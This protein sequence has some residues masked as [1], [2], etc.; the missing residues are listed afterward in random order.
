M[1]KKFLI[2]PLLCVAFCFS[3]MPSYSENL[4][5]NKDFSVQVLNFTLAGDVLYKLDSGNTTKLY[6]K[7]SAI[8]N[9]KQTLYYVR[10]SGDKWIAGFFRGNAS[11][12][13]EFV[14]PG[15][16]IKIYKFTGK[17]NI[18]YFLAESLPENTDG[19]VES[20]TAFIRFNP[21]Q[22]SCQ[23][24]E[25]V[26]DYELI[27]GKSV[28]LKNGNLDSNGSQIPLMLT[29]KLKISRLIDS[30]I[31]VISGADGTEL[32]DLAA[33][34]SIYQYKENFIPEYPSETN[35]I[36]EF[37]DSMTKTPDSSD[38]DNSIYYVILIDGV[39]ESR[40]ETGRGELNKIY[41]AKLA[42]GKYHIIKPERWELD[43]VKGRYARMNNIYQPGELK[44][45]IPENRILKIKIE[46]NGTSYVVNQ[47]VLYK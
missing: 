17:D 28:I 36:L 32:V 16:Y 33:G 10:N 19:S 15:K 7:V 27:D 43:K 12:S 44:I 18:F 41:N 30:R 9:G 31:A 45:Y 2:L 25:G 37:G 1:T 21:D 4:S 34:K 5:I 35:L 40:T 39:E 13:I 11:I 6:D 26:E 22:M 29:G 24:I 3:I 42:A 8:S 46:F 23:S 47:S 14:I 38:A 20:H